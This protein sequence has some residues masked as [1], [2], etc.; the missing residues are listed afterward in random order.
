MR[1]RFRVVILAAIVVAI[2]VPLALALTIEPTHQAP[3]PPPVTSTV[4]A[5][6]T[7]TGT[8]GLLRQT[9]PEAYAGLPDGAKLFLMGTVLFALAAGVKRA[10]YTHSRPPASSSRAYNRDNS[11]R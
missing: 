2:V 8:T 7:T 1:K 5:M 4:V 9:A 6:T 11:A 3:M 10:V